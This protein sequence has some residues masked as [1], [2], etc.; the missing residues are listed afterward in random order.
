LK[1]LIWI[2]PDRILQN[3]LMR[4]LFCQRMPSSG[5]GKQDALQ[6]MAID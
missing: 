3:I 2:W 6:N 1:L 5:G 4:Y